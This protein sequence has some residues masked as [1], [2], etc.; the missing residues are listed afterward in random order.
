[1]A[2]DELG[3]HDGDLRE[4]LDD[5]IG[6]ADR[7]ETRIRTILDFTRPLALAAAPGDLGSF[8][9]HFAEG[10]RARLPPGVRLD[11]EV[12]PALPAVSFDPKAL[13]EVVETI[14]VNAVEAMRGDG[15]IRLRAALEPHDRAVPD[16]VVSVSDT[17]PGLEAQA[18]RRVFDLFYTTKQAGTGVGLAMAKRLVER[19]GGSIDVE[20]APGRGATFL[21]RLPVGG[22][23][24][25]R[26]S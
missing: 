17:G 10:F 21:I 3:E 6:E 18:Q 22:R 16:A 12:D 24:S 25:A 14:A 5:I 9:G 23:L 19:Q 4:S 8:L 26:T 1:V 20:S 13:G 15:V 11:L 7:L 2:R